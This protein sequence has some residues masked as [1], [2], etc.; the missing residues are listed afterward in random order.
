MRNTLLAGILMLLFLG[1]S[2]SPRP[3]REW[4]TAFEVHVVTHDAQSVLADMD[5]AYRRE[6]HDQ[7][8]EGNTERFLAEFFCGTSSDGTF[9][10]PENWEQ[11]TDV[12]FMGM[13]KDKENGGYQVTYQIGLE[14]AGL[15]EVS[16]H[17]RMKGKTILGFEG[18]R[19]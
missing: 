13:R 9:H 17:L 5:A 14:K 12:R 6:Q 15:V 19:G 7:F 8:H 3:V 10:C 1:A 2:A 16:W 18:A 4:L 11:I